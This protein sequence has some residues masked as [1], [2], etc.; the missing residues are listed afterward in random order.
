MRESMNR[1]SAG[2]KGRCLIILIKL[3]SQTKVYV[4]HDAGRGQL[5]KET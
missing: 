1:V 5:V 3:E 4:M 2:Q